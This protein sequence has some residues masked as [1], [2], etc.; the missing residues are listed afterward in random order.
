M[1][2][3]RLAKPRVRN[4]GPWTPATRLPGARSA[5]RTVL[6]LSWT[7]GRRELLVV[8]VAQLVSALSAPLRILVLQRLLATG[9]T[10]H[11]GSLIATLL[12]F[13]ALLALVGY[14]KLVQLERG[15]L[16]GD[17]VT[18][19]AAARVLDAAQSTELVCFEDSR[20]HDSVGRA[21]T[22]QYRVSQAVSAFFQMTSGILASIAVLLV[23]TSVKW[24]LLPVV[25][26]VAVPISIA[27]RFN[28][29]DEH[30]FMYAIMGL[31][32][33]RS[34]CE[35]LLL[36]REPAKEVRAF[37]LAPL[38]R[39]IHDAVYDE[40]IRKVRSLLAD[41][42]RRSLLSGILTSAAAGAFVTSLIGLYLAGKMT[43]ATAGTA[44]YAVSALAGQ[45]TAVGRSINVLYESLLVVAELDVFVAGVAPPSRRRKLQAAPE[46]AGVAMEE[47]A[48][49]YPTA[50]VPAVDGVS[51]EIAA[52]EVI[53]LVG[54]NGSGKTTIAKLLA[55]LYTPE[56]GRIIWSGVDTRE[57]EPAT[58][59]D[60]V[61]IGFQDFEHFR[62]SVADNIG[63]GR[64][65]RRHNRHEI[66]YA[67]ERAG[68]G[69]FISSLPESYETLLGPE[70]VGGHDLSE[71]QWQRVAL[72][73]V[74][75][76]DAPLVILDEP[77]AA[78]DPLAECQLFETMKLAL[79]G[80]CAVLISHRL[81]S[82]R[83]ADRIYVLH[84]GRVIES[85]CHLELM[86]LG[87]HYSRLFNT[88]AS[89]YISVGSPNGRA[90][91]GRR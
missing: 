64:H 41:Q 66:R 80:R 4:G 20:F 45:L 84:H 67:A 77:T 63:A 28:A 91:A 42:A 62:M 49:T 36:D 14:A 76:R 70:F 9:A 47:V 51:L 24:F 18:R 78:L 85:G 71:G 12:I 55:A 50:S 32:R 25:V 87:G 86:S 69:E 57:I 33:R 23:L 75:F 19:A 83:M 56:R 44:G 89:A 2:R 8:A 26:L 1:P 88:Q 72:A 82:V 60:Q 68:V 34:Y 29:S 21:Q 59:R 3:L 31:D 13:G 61:A 53:A 46:F 11:R 81:S 22:G 52:G 48:F 37:E 10:D 16:L 74:F 58:L 39:A 65:E 90:A 7:A 40:R 79:E 5:L 15:R 38:I 30:R 17:L 73:R 35:S 54:A 43:L 27:S 6:E